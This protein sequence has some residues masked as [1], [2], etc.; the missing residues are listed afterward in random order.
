MSL[1]TDISGLYQNVRTTNGLTIGGSIAQIMQ[2]Y[3]NTNWIDRCTSLVINNNARSRPVGGTRTHGDNPYERF[4]SLD[5]IAQEALFITPGNGYMLCY[6]IGGNGFYGQYSYHSIYGTTTAQGNTY[7]WDSVYPIISSD[8]K[9]K[10]IGVVGV[11]ARNLAGQTWS[12]SLKN[13][14]NVSS[15]YPYITQASIRYYYKSNLN[16][17]SLVMCDLSFLPAAKGILDTYM[18]NAYDRTT[19][20]RGLYCNSLGTQ[21]LSGFSLSSGIRTDSE[22]K[23]YYAVLA[24]LVGTTP[25]K[26]AKLYP[27]TIGDT[28]IAPFVYYEISDVVAAANSRGLWWAEDQIEAQNNAKGQNTISE[29]VH[30]PSVSVNGITS[31]TDSS[32]SDIYYNWTTD[33]D[34]D[35][36]GGDLINTNTSNN[37]SEDKTN[38]YE[39]LEQVTNNEENSNLEPGSSSFTGVGCFATYYAMTP[40]QIENFNDELWSSDEEWY[41][42]LISGLKLWGADPMQAVM[43]LRLYP[44]NVGNLVAGASATAIKFGRVEMQSTGY[45]VHSNSTIILDLGSTWINVQNLGLHGDFRDYSPY[46]EVTLYIPF[47]G[48]T[49]INVNDFMNTAM[50]IK[51]TVDITTGSCC[52]VVYADNAPYLYLPGT[53]GVEIP[54]TLNT[55]TEVAVGIL[56]STIGLAAGAIGGVA[57]TAIAMGGCQFNKY[58]GITNPNTLSRMYAA[59]Q[60][61]EANEISHAATSA[62]TDIGNTSAEI[63]FGKSSMDRTGNSSPAA[64]L[65]QPLYCYL[66]VSTP[67]WERPDNYDH[68]YGK[69]CHESGQLRSYT[70]FTICRNVDASGITCTKVEQEMIQN[71]LESGVYL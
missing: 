26:L 49:Q 11:S 48:L 70:G 30:A 71:Y 38:E 40:T 42:A 69:I 62:L 16:T 50:R 59:E 7:N 31:D 47:V 32:G 5:T 61:Q 23:Y 46:T 41:N 1:P 63:I 3:G 2:Y 24:G 64:A 35:L 57:G 9:E 44:F 19:T 36:G 56:Q 12:G 20:Y 10:Y 15:T 55:M 34:R 28:N 29:Y 25:F 27:G 54:I 4:H 66:I 33:N 17:N 14:R 8:D 21:L 53:I 67:T 43:S 68:T 58:A 45:K 52:A 6:Q 60:E 51:M 18:L 65:T 22:G 39:K 13:Y 37:A